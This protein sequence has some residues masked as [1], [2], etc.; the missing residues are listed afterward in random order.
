MARATITLSHSVLSTDVTLLCDNIDV[1][2]TRKVTAKPHANS[3]SLAQAQTQSQENPTYNI[4]GVHFTGDTGTLSFSELQD[5]FKIDYDGT[6][7]ISL[8]ITYGK[9]GSTQDLPGFDGSSPISVVMETFDYPLN[10]RESEG[11]YMPVGTITFRET[12]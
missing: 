12:A 10:A 2:Y 4:T 9:S 5:L 1:G 7:P 8:T 6:N 3:G 11:G